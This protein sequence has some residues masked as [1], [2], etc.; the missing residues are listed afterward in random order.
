MAKRLL[1]FLIV[2]LVSNTQYAQSKLDRPKL[3]V[4]IVVDQMRHD[5]LYRYYDKYSEN[6]FK[7][8]LK[9][10][11]SCENL[12]Y[13]YAPTVTA[14]GHASIYTG[15]TPAY[16]AIIGNEWFQRYS[17]KSMYCVEDESVSNVG[18]TTI[19][20]GKKSPKNLIAS[21]MTDELRL[22]FYNKSK[23]IGLSIKDRGSILPAG[24]NPTGAYWYDDQ[25]GNFITSTY[26][27]DNLPDWVSKFN[28]EK[29]VPK[30]LSQGWN[31]LKPIN[32][33][34][35]STT[36]L[37]PYEGKLAGEKDPVFPRVFDMSK[38]NYGAINV[39]PHGNTML[40]EIALRAIAG[41]SLGTDEITDFLALSY[42]GPDY[43][44]HLFGLQSIEIEDIYLRLDL[45]IARLLQ[46]LDEK[47]GKNQYLLFLSA[48]HAVAQVP[49]FLM[50]QRH[51]AGY[52]SSVA[53]MDSLKKMLTKKY[54]PNIIDGMSNHQI[55]LNE[56]RISFKKLNRSAIVSDIK[57]FLQNMPGVFQVWDR[58]EIPSLSNNLPMNRMIQLGFNTNRGGDIIYALLPAWLE[59]S[60][61]TGTSHSS[62]YN[63]DTHVPGL[64]FGW[65]VP[66]GKSYARY[67]ITDIAPTITHMTKITLP[68]ASIGKVIEFVK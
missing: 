34:T 50:D 8:I 24:H 9:E 5:Y 1:F 44:G 60:F 38:P 55:Y 36:D 33:Y 22:F 7:R 27:R 54:D 28:N 57:S 41:E 68:N 26:Y 29:W 52:L 20:A 65:S 46:F 56:D 63:Y 51:S 66:A 14:P 25:S 39:T 47:V 35:E 4:G 48:D 40:T 43:A 42:S 12:H 16:H 21:T 6:G 37:N 64:F 13:N 19:A 53:M 18:S 58:S 10:G 17:R 32:E 61:R 2:V 49:Q 67:E 59:S 23:V 31:T 30:L 11:F 15:T 45:E 62:P 3:I